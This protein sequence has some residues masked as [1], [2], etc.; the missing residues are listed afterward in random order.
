[1]LGWRARN[2]GLIRNHKQGTRLVCAY[3]E[4]FQQLCQELQDPERRFCVVA[5]AARGEGRSTVAI[6]L[7]TVAARETNTPALLIDADTDSPSLHKPFRM[8]PGPGLA[9][10]I[11]GEASL[12]DVIRPAGDEGVMIITGGDAPLS[13]VVLAESKQ[14]DTFIQELRPRFG[15]IFADTAPLLNAP[16]MAKFDRRADGVLLAVRW[17]HTRLQL[18]TQAM[19]KLDTTQ[20]KTLGVVLTQRHYT[21]PSYVYRRL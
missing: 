2:K 1:M 4:L 5:S 10:L 6:N 17:S 12:D 18:V 14:L 15:W 13:P 20:A 21:I 19:E 7:A 11:A 16:G 3:Q 9:D 8:S